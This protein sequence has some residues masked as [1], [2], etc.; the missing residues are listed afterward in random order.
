MCK[1]SG[2][3]L[4]I[5]VL[6]FSIIGFFGMYFVAYLGFKIAKLRFCGISLMNVIYKKAKNERLS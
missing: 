6:F 3:D 4:C 2:Y 5:T 1:E